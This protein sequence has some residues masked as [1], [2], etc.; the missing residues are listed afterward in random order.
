MLEIKVDESPLRVEYF[1]V[2]FKTK[3][4][5]N[6]YVIRVEL[7]TERKVIR[8]LKFEDKLLR[9]MHLRA[10]LEVL[11]RLKSKGYTLGD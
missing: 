7:D 2:S 3:H 8:E 9:L 4:W 11:N 6:T 10:I 5:T 1:Y